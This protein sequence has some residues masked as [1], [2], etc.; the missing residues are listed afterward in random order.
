MPSFS[1]ICR[2]ASCSGQGQAHKEQAWQ[3]WRGAAAALGRILRA[4]ADERRRLC[5]DSAKVHPTPPPHATA[6]ATTHRHRARRLHEQRLHR[7]VEQVDLRGGREKR[8]RLGWRRRA[9]KNKRA[10]KGS[11]VPDDG[12]EPV[13][14][15]QLAAHTPSGRPCRP[16]SAG[17]PAKREGGEEAVVRQIIF[18][19]PPS[20]PFLRELR[21][22]DCLHGKCGQRTILTG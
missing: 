20:P 4:R 14:L 21:C 18:G 16:A 22:L 5:E 17:P 7:V 19:S 9:G 11:M 6:L 13:K 8:G 2:H 1:A 12:A 10:R 15:A 3:H